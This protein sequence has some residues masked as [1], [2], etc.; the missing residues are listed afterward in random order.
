MSWI[1]SPSSGGYSERS[2]LAELPN[3]FDALLKPHAKAHGEIFLRTSIDLG[4]GEDRNEPAEKLWERS[5]NGDLSPALL[6]KIFDSG[7]YAI[8]SSCGDWPPKLQGVWAGTWGPPWSSDYTLNGNVQTAIASLLNGNMPECL[9]SFFDYLEWLVPHCKINARRLYGCRGIFLASRTSTHGL[10]N[11][12]DATWP[13]T[14]WTTGAAWCSQFFHDYYLYTGDREFLAKARAA[15]YE[16]LGAVLR[17]FPDRGRK[18]QVF[19]SPSYSPENNPSNN[20]SQACVNATMDIA[21]VKELLTNLIAACEELG[22]EPDGV[23]RWKAMLAKMPGVYDQHRW[24]GQ[25]MDHART[26]RQLSPQ[27]LLASAIRCITASRRISRRTR[28]F[29]RDSGRRWIIA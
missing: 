19:F 14:F 9:H 8:L 18:R 22:V 27:A 25:G 21:I 13:M 28:R 6:E 11:H 12:F 10:Q 7:R 16:G 20:P 24:R 3:S 17:G 2:T 1:V 15:V 29:W 26:R 23:A 5:H 4:G